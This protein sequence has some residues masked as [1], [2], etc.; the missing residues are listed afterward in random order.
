MLP[1]LI[2]AVAIAGYEITIKTIVGLCLACAVS[3]LGYRAIT[4]M[5]GS[6]EGESSNERVERIKIAWITFLSG[7]AIIVVL[8]KIGLISFNEITASLN[9]F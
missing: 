6:R 8:G 2:F 4:S 9:Q 7:V 5:A 1:S 3:F